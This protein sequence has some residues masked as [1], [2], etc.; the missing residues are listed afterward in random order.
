MFGDL[1]WPVNASRGLSAIAEFLVY[2]SEAEKKFSNGISQPDNGLHHLLPP[3][4]DTQLITRMPYANTYP[5]PIKKN[6][7]VRLSSLTVRIM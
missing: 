5:V 7:F 3:L 4:R 6:G 2:I 1:D